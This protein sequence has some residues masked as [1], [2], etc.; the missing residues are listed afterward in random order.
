[1]TEQRYF[2]EYFLVGYYGE[3]FNRN[4]RGKQFIY[5]GFE[6]ERIAEFVQVRHFLLLFVSLSFLLLLETLG[7]STSDSPVVTLSLSLLY[8]SMSL[9]YCS[10]F[11]ESIRMRNCSSP[12]NHRMSLSMR[13]TA[14]TC[15][16]ST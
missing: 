9:W 2:S 6:L 13:P 8:S 12:L 4:L 7:N 5:R 11:E 16:C 3:G 10:E 14:S 1:V 15:K